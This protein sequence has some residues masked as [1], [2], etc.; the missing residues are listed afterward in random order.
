MELEIKNLLKQQ[1]FSATK[2]RMAVLGAILKMQ[3]ASMQ[4]LI[5]ALPDVDRATVYRTVDLFVE[6]N[7]AKKVHTG[8]KYRVELSDSFQEH[9]HHLTCLRCGTVLDVHTP[10]IE[11]AIDQT[12]S[13]NGFRPVRH[14]LEIIGY[15]AQCS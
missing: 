8:F 7:I 12:A 10:E 13:S 4:Q 5:S 1:G 11:Y 6:L 2:T 15:C 9:H 3:P 14:D